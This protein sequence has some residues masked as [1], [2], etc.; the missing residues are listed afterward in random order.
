MLKLKSSHNDVCLP[1][2]KKAKNV[3]F[4]DPGPKP[5]ILKG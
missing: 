3:G 4:R 1:K 5:Q 2:E